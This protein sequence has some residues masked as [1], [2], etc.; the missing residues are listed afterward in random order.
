MQIILTNRAENFL[1]LQLNRQYLF[2]LIALLS[3]DI[4]KTLL[5]LFKYNK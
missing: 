5:D 1:V 4:K 2:A 3:R